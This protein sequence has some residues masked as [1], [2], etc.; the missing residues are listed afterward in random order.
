M[1]GPEAAGDTFV[2]N[3]AQMLGITCTLYD[4][5]ILQ[6]DCMSSILTG[7]LPSNSATFA[8]K[9]AFRV[10]KTRISSEKDPRRSNAIFAAYTL[11]YF[12]G[13]RYN[14]DSEK[15]WDYIQKLR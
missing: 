12:I 11:L 2:E 9:E 10:F 4:Q 6:H 5:E 3:Y 8:M 13:D 7:L 14:K 15:G 1:D